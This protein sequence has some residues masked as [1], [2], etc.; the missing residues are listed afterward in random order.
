M[1][2]NKNHDNPTSSF[3]RYSRTLYNTLHSV[4]YTLFISNLIAQAPGLNL[5]VKS[6]KVLSNCEA[7][8]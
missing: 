5:G 3:N 8:N 4:S 2:K 7:V 6:R 1:K